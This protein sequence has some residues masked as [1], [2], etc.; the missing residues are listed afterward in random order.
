MIIN[1]GYFTRPGTPD[2]I[3]DVV[4]VKYRGDKYCCAMIR[5]IGAHNGILYGTIKNAK[6]FYHK[7]SHWQKITRGV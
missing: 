2:L 1:K 6:L 7:I 4:K 5:L 3:I